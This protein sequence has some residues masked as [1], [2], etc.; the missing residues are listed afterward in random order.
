[1]EEC[2]F[3]G[4]QIGQKALLHLVGAA[5]C[6]LYTGFCGGKPAGTLL[7]YTRNQV[8]GLYMITTLPGFRKRGIARQLTKTALRDA[9]SGKCLYAV[10]E[11]TPMGLP[12]Y[13]KAGFKEYCNF[14][15]YWMMGKNTD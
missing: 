12:L 13:H 8:A 14:D 5:E 3:N 9:A 6:C 10:L 11:S 7:S 2:L 15:I 1:V 4:R